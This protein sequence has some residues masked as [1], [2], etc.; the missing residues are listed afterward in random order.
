MLPGGGEAPQLAFSRDPGIAVAE[1]SLREDE[2]KEQEPSSRVKMS[3]SLVCWVQG[4]CAAAA[5]TLSPPQQPRVV[6]MALRRE[7]INSMAKLWSYTT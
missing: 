4:G 5:F 2:G 6:H 3:W 1:L 7:M